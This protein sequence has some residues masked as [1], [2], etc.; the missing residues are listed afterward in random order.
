MRAPRT[1]TPI[2]SHEVKDAEPQDRG[3]SGHEAGED[4]A[5]VNRPMEASYELAEPTDEDEPDEP[6][7]QQELRS[8]QHPRPANRP[9]RPGKKGHPEILR[10]ASMA[11]ARSAF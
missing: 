3:D 4:R 6:C 11:R 2:T 9:T 5:E 1:A 8:E 10:H 7:D